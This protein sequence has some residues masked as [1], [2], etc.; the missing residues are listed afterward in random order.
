[1]AVDLSTLGGAGAQFFDNNGV[2]LS[3][4]KLY[5]YAASTTTPKATFTSSS[6]NVPHTN[7]IILDSSGRVPSGGEIWLTSGEAYKFVL[8]T[9]TGILLGTWDNIY[10]YTTGTADASSEVQTATAGQTLFVLNSMAYNPGTNTLAVYIDG[11]NQVVNNSYIE[12]NNTS[13]T[14]VAGLHEGAVVKFSKINIGATDAN[15]VSYEPGFLGSVA[16]TVADKLQQYISVKDFGAVGDGVAD[17][18]AAIQAALDSAKSLYFPAG[19]YLVDPLTIPYSARGAVYTGAG[20]FH[21][22]DTQQ[23]VI[24]A[25]TAGQ[26]HI[27]LVGNSG[28]SGADCLTFANMR[29]DCD[30]KAARAIDATYGAFF[31][32]KDCGVYDYTAFGVYHKQ[33]L[34]RYDRVFM[35]TSSSTNPTAVGLHLYS[36]SAVSDS[37]FTGGGVPL[38]LVAGGNR[39][40][41]I[42]A[43]SGSEACISLEPFDNSTTHINTSMVNV[44]AGEVSGGAVSKPI[45]KMVGTAAQKVQEVQFSNS[46]LVTASGSPANKINGGILMDYCDAIAVS[47][48]VIRGNGLLAT[49]TQYCDYFAKISNTKTVTIT[50]CIIKDVNKNPIY[51]VSGVDQAVV[52]SGCSFYNWAVDAFVTG[53]EAAAIRCGTSMKAN[54]T[55]CTFHIDTGSATPYA[56]DCNSAGDISF[57]NNNVSYA[58]ATVVNAASGN[59]RYIIQRSGNAEVNNYSIEKSTIASSTVNN[60][61]KNYLDTGTAVSVAFTTQTLNLRTFNNVSEQQVYLA[62]ASQQGNGASTI[63][64]ML[65]MYANRTAAVRIAGDTAGLTMSFSGLQLQLNVDNS[66]PGPLTWQWAITRLV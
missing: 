27:F 29:L 64:Y 53:A 57:V 7:P 31:T 24:K 18:T 28:G 43:N 20:F 46:Y 14:F 52:V 42:W 16:T 56:A 58:S 37:E 35:S 50:D 8:E 54:V 49:A 44:Y 21:Y 11:V 25:R 65:N 3:G 40:S 47:N 60:A 48:V 55:G 23:T 36:D 26:S 19:V 32:M 15:V 61:G 2:P 12:T 5:S 13:V 17:D 34:A 22:A 4:G 59:P 33:G 6:G 38:K 66:F 30:N 1:M 45:V 62:T 39:I 41:N 9:S 10:G 63:I 51:I